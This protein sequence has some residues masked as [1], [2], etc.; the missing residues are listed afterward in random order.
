MSSSLNA[1]EFEQRLLQLRLEQDPE[2]TLRV[3]AEL[4]DSAFMHR[5]HAF[6]HRKRLQG[7][8]IW[9]LSTSHDVNRTVDAI[10]QLLE[11]VCYC[12]ARMVFLTHRFITGTKA[13]QRFVRKALQRNLRK[14]RSMVELLVRDESRARQRIRE[15]FE[16][17]RTRGKGNV[18]SQ[19]TV[20]AL[21][22]LYLDCWT[23]PAIVMEAVNQL[24]RERRRDFLT[25]Y[26]SYRSTEIE[27]YRARN[28][29]TESEFVRRHTERQIAA[30][31]PP[32]SFS[33]ANVTVDNIA[34]VM[35]RLA[36]AY[37]GNVSRC[38]V[39]VIPPY[40]Y[41][42]ALL[43]FDPKRSHFALYLKML[44]DNDRTPSMNG[45]SRAQKTQLAEA[46]ALAHD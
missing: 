40:S 18:A 7:F 39:A 11:A 15:S 1:Q 31:F 33:L 35:A 17:M 3:L 5:W 24:W 26:R 21:W 22:L 9:R 34:L 14:K 42:H 30:S 45:L 29:G 44:V 13:A 41:Y 19:R 27:K 46:I 37:G 20:D 25:S 16:E 28:Q 12:S 2:R 8:N 4:R 43:S 23:N 10:K 6:A 38:T 36:N 32:P